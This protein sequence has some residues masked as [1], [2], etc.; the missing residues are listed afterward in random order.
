MKISQ[1]T[2]LS[3]LLPLLTTGS[4]HSTSSQ[5]NSNGVNVATAIS[6]I[7]NKD[8]KYNHSPALIK[9][10]KQYHDDIIRNVNPK[11]QIHTYKL[12]ELLEDPKKYILS[13]LNSNKG[14]IKN[15]LNGAVSTAKYTF[16]VV[17]IVSSIL[18]LKDAL[19]YLKCTDECNPLAP[20]KNTAC[21][22]FFWYCAAIALCHTMN[23]DHLELSLFLHRFKI[24]YEALKAKTDIAKAITNADKAIANTAKEAKTKTDTAKGN[25]NH[26]VEFFKKLKNQKDLRSRMKAIKD[27]LKPL[28]EREGTIIHETAEATDKIQAL[29]DK[30][31][32]TPYKD[33]AALKKELSLL[34]RGAMTF[35]KEGNSLKAKISILIK[36]LMGIED[37]L[38]APALEPETFVV[39]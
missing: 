39:S 34:C 7:I 19:D 31:E 24:E 4:I 30:I 6:N 26:Q 2:R 22:V 18:C 17:S 35:S 10:A 5:V 36:E 37:K 3:I 38:Y 29:H 32:A 1:I 16:G 25:H 20:I 14:R 15:I 33:T 8:N 21:G 11:G 27:E 9:A 12:S 28:Y 13:N 23:R